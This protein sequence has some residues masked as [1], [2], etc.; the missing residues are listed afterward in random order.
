MIFELWND[1]L[2]RRTLVGYP[3]PDWK[4]GGDGYWYPPETATN[5]GERL[6]DI[7]EQL[8]RV[9]AQIKKYK[10][11]SG[12]I[13]LT[14]KVNVG[15]VPDPAHLKYPLF[16]SVYP[17][18]PSFTSHV[19]SIFS[20]LK[21]TSIPLRINE[22]VMQTVSNLL[23]DKITRFFDD[24]RQLKTLVNFGN[25][26]QALI[27]NW[28]YDSQDGTGAT[29]VAKLY[30]PLPLDVETKT[31]VWISRE[32]SP[33]V[34][35]RLHVKFTPPA[36]PKVYLRPPNKSINLTGRTGQSIEKVTLG[37]L[38]SSGA[39]SPIKQT[40]PV[41]EEWYTDDINSVELNIDYSNYSNFVFFGSARARLE[42]FV[43]K[44]KL[45]ESYDQ[46]LNFNSASLSVSGS[47]GVTSSLSYP[48]LKSV[49]EKRLGVIRS[50]DPYERF[51]YYESGIP[52]SS[53]FGGDEDDEFYYHEDATW[54]KISGSVVPVASASA[55]LDAQ[56]DIAIAYDRQNQNSLV[57]SLPQYI[58]DDIESKDFVTFIEM[59]GHQFDI[60]KPYID[61]MTNIY[62]RG[63]DATK[64]IS[65]DIIWNVAESFGVELPN[66]YAINKLIDFTVGSNNSLNPKVY[67]EIAA[68]TWKRFLHNQIFMM[69]TKGTKT[70]LRTLANSYGILP[71]MLQIREGVIT[72]YSDPTQSFE[73]YEEQTN[74]L[75]IPTD[76]YIEIPWSASTPQTLEIRFSTLDNSTNTVLFNA[77][78][79]WA[80]TLV[81]TSEEYGVVTLM[82]ASVATV[83]SSIL[84][85]YNGEYY[86]VMVRNNP[87]GS[88]LY[89]KKAEENLIVDESETQEASPG[90]S[91]VF[92]QSS[93]AFIGGSG[94]YFGRAFSGN[95]DEVRV[96]SESLTNDVFDNHVKYPGLYGGNTTTSARDNLRVRLSFSKPKNL[97]GSD[98]TIPNE[99]P[100]AR[101]SSDLF[102]TFT[103]VGFP[104]ISTTPYNMDIIVREVTRFNPNAGGSN[105]S[106]NNVVI[107]DDPTLVY[108]SGSNIPVLS[109]YTSIMPVSKK[110]EKTQP[111]NIVGF[112]FSVTDAINDSIIRSIGNIDIGDLIGDP[113][114]QYQTKYSALEQLNNL[115]WESYAYNFNVNNFVDFVRNLL[116]PLFKQ[117]RDLVPVRA[118]LLSGIVHEPH[119]LERPKIKNKPVKLSAGKYGRDNEI[120]NLEAVPVISRPEEVSGEFLLTEIGYNLNEQS[121]INASE[122]LFEADIQ[123]NEVIVPT[124]LYDDYDATITAQNV[125]TVIGEYQSDDGNINIA[126]QNLP[127][128]QFIYYDD[129]TNRINYRN[130][131]LEEF[132]VESESDLSGEE[133]N[134]FNYKLST[135]KSPSTINIKEQYLDAVVGKISV[136]D[137]YFMPPVI[138]PTTDFDS[139]E[140]YTYFTNPDG[141][142]GTTRIDYVRVGEK[143]QTERGT[144]VK[145]TTYNRDDVVVQENATGDARY[146]N[147]IEF[148]C[149]TTNGSF[150]S[151]I[152]P[153]LDTKNWRPATYIP[154][155]KLVV[156]KVVIVNG[157]V[158]LAP[159]TSGEQTVHGYRPSHY[160]F[161]RD[162]RKGILNHLWLGCLQTDDTTID[163][164]PAV[165]INFTGGDILVVKDGSEPIQDSSD[166][167]GPILDVQ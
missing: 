85:I 165:Q 108:I 142:I 6:E 2:T 99:S 121:E 14:V 114:D 49:S 45:I 67:R 41:I 143:I 37:T 93:W 94:S 105:F 132:G 163:G 28:K 115:Y 75:K 52:Y 33:P 125:Q 89:V 90:V 65:S 157:E 96:W 43:R 98:K 161:T 30:Q 25:D 138:K 36:P 38:F 145:G 120:Q 116:G 117:A 128:A 135:Y 71:T 84:P 129:F 155:E 140:S 18:V 86:S 73:T 158:S 13:N 24:S 160:K 31:Q 54:P 148:V 119:I 57:N 53:S 112:Y 20:K 21:I 29:I 97:G 32:L 7:K 101:N 106:T 141:Y 83:S 166:Q 159:I 109:P 62:K 58:T 100:Y 126:D 156:K 136:S 82:S 167:A 74:V 127:F 150:T 69:K 76:S 68:E 92:D 133:L 151:N 44:L 5:I 103:A 48:A 22:A 88:E 59:I 42:A 124:A 63:N 113:S 154:T 34:I 111:S 95:V 147:G 16:V 137:G 56:L 47:T 107:A 149:I 1:G 134:T 152:E 9:Y 3:P 162:R 27:T 131:L 164:R 146:G 23:K 130:E 77:G 139:I 51:L 66:Q 15:S 12:H 72:G 144:W 122:H 123:N 26:Y 35:D 118:K 78:N 4:Q 50:F 46:I 17:A 19:K 102:K 153:Y 61:Q 79:D 80:L 81:P 40:D 70:A 91:L 39:F 104:N 55:W 87:S 8:E 64:E 10:A 60:L 110:E 11:I